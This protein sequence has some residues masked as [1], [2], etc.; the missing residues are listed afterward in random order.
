M[1]QRLEGLLIG[2]GVG[3]GLGGW[4]FISLHAVPL[5]ALAVGAIVGLPVF[6]I[7][8]SRPNPVDAAADAAW[9]AA[10]RDLP[11]ASDRLTLEAAQE[12]IDAPVARRRRGRGPVAAAAPGEPGADKIDGSAGPAERDP[13]LRGPRSGKGMERS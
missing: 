10:A 4:V 6:A 12:H 11:P 9:R 7:V 2:A 13:V 8:A 1:R 5:V 3:I